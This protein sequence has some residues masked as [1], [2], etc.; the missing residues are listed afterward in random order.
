VTHGHPLYVLGDGYGM[1]EAVDSLGSDD[2]VVRAARVSYANDE[3]EKDPEADTR[4]IRYLARNGHYTPFEHCVLT[5]H[6]VCPL[7]IARQWM[8]H[9]A[10]S[11][12]EI[13]RRYTSEEIR[14]YIPKTW[15]RQAED[16]RQASHGELATKV[17]THLL[18]KHVD[19]AASLYEE[20]LEIGVAREQ[21][22]MVLPQ[23][24]YTR[25]YVTGDLR[26]WAHFVRLR[27][28][29]DAQYEMQLYAKAVRD[30]LYWTFPRS[31]AALLEEER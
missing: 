22:R 12:N 11:Y 7:F 16:N 8:R 9:R 13:S 5:L 2:T 18:F 17:P 29:P 15:R 26:N 20:L 31:A 30:I 4:L 19:A 27:I 21:A 6:V 3:V 1:V 24:L 28:A 14:F 10:F 25:Y 23:N